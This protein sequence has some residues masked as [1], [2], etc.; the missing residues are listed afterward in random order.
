MEE[1]AMNVQMNIL[2]FL[3][4]QNVYVTIPTLWITQIFVIKL[5]EPANVCL[6][7]VG[8]T[9][10]IVLMDISTF[11]HVKVNKS[12]FLKQS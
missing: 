10:I 5:M 3:I 9:A 4:A 11:L 8:T 6:D 2:V 1:P 7:M 12:A